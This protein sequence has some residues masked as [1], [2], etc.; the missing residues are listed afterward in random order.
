MNKNKKIFVIAEAGV[1]HNGS[2]S[3]AKKLAKVAVKAGADAVKFQ[4][5]KAKDE[6]TR[7]APLAEYQRKN[8][9]KFSQYEM[10]KKLELSHPRKKYNNFALSYR[11][12]NFHVRCKF[13][14]NDKLKKKI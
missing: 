10:V 14:C 3:I 4:T 11:L 5:F 6:I 7:Q 8:S 13:T 12:S 9:K 2:I 1:N